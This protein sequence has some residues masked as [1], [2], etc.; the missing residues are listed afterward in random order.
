M[1]VNSPYVHNSKRMLKL[2][3]QDELT[4]SMPFSKHTN[5]K[6]NLTHKQIQE[7]SKTSKKL[8]KTIF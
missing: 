8:F 3:R 5:K 2:N 4:C 6:D 1:V 7:R